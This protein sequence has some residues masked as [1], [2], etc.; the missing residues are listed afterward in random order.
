[1]PAI[2]QS[3]Y[4]TWDAG[5]PQFVATRFVPLAV[6]QSSSRWRSFKLLSARKIGE[7]FSSKFYGL[8]ARS[9]FRAL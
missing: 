2:W 3:N 6:G 1:M 5:Q 4:M 9:R 8:Q 7:I